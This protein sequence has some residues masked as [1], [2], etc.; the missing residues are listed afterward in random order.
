MKPI[1]INGTLKEGGGIVVLPKATYELEITEA[2]ETIAKSS[3]NP[4]LQLT[5]SVMSGDHASKTFMSWFVLVEKAF[6]RISNL[7]EACDPD[8]EAHSLIP[9]DEKDD[10]G[11]E[12]YTID[13]PDVSALV[14]R[15]FLGE[16]EPS[17]DNKGREFT[18]LTNMFA[19]ESA[20]DSS[21]EAAAP[22][23]EEKPA[24]DKVAPSNNAAASGGRR[25]RV[26]PTA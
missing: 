20:T 1:R 15:C 19:M 8:Q 3:N 26:R 24:Q 17:T 12:I 7:L 5:L 22:A 16:C 10:N 6:W 14:G 21:Q 2:K 11:D 4:Q 9:T 13:L 18:N 25:R 23:V